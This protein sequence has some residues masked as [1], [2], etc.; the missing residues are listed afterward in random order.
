MIVS[1][2][3]G[4]MAI[5][6][7]LD[8]TVLRALHALQKRRVKCTVATGRG[9]FRL[10]KCLGSAFTPNFPMILE[11]GGRICKANG[12][13]LLARPVAPRT[14]PIV[15]KF[16][17]PRYVR[18]VDFF[19]LED[20]KYVVLEHPGMQ[21]SPG[22]VFLAEK[23]VAARYDNVDA[24]MAHVT[25]SRCCKLTFFP[26]DEKKIP[27][28]KCVNASRN[29]SYE[30]V[31]RRHVSKGAALRQL[32]EMSDIPLSETLIAGNDYNDVKLFEL[33]AR[34]RIAVG[35][36]CPKLQKRATCAVATPTAFGELL[37]T[38]I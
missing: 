26:K 35:N 31:M 16:M 17:F 1:D 21:T 28:P 32:C 20:N 15:R 25:A 12:S 8:A 11:N 14:F 23:F 27:F 38:F 3:D 18:G 10:Q 33:P 37:Q 22:K 7:E 6:G 2:I 36:D 24:F 19:Q 4:V 29:E 34:W 13:P 9:Y 5:D 30:T